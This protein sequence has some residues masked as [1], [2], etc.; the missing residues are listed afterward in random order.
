MNIKKLNVF[1]SFAGAGGFSLGFSQAGFNVVG[2]SELDE[3]ACDTFRANHPG[4]PVI[5]G[6]ITKISDEEIMSVIKGKV[7]ILL[8]GPPCQGF[9]IANKRNVDF[10]DPRNSLFTEF[11]RLGKLFKPKVMI[12]EN[13]PNIVNARTHKGEKVTDIIEEEMKNLGY[14]VYSTILEATNYGVPQIRKRFVIIG[15]KTPLNIPFPKPTH[16]INTNNLF[17]GVLKQCPTLWDAISD[18]P[19]LKSGEEKTKYE[20]PPQTKYQKLIRGG[21]SSLYNHIA[22]RHSKRKIYVYGMGSKR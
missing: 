6:D 19:S 13:V 7:D 9:S 10:K 8:G 21:S 11:L 1:D 12:M 22:M 2:A 15:S 14:F 3:W 4:V 18:L 16:T 5:E 20:K 17:S